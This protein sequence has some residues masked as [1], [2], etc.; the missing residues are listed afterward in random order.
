MNSLDLI[1]TE[2]KIVGFLIDIYLKKIFLRKFIFKFETN[3]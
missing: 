3:N 2:I 1:S